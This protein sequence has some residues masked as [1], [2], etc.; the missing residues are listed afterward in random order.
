MSKK[1]RRSTCPGK[2]G[3]GL[4]LMPVA[5]GTGDF[6]G[7]LGFESGCTLNLGPAS[8]PGEE[9]PLSKCFKCPIC[10]ASEV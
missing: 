1:C 4:V 7:D 8:L 2:L 10:G 3:T 9:A 6:A 5:F